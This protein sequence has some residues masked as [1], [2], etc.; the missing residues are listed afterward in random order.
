MKIAV[1]HMDYLRNVAYKEL[2][3]MCKRKDRNPDFVVSRQ[4]LLLFSQMLT[5]FHGGI[6]IK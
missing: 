2:I 3:L 6:R 5:L 4:G 1:P